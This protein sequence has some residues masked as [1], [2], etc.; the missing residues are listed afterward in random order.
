M[1]DA[2]R[3]RRFSPEILPAQCCLGE[4]S[5]HTLGPYAVLKATYN[6][7]I[8]MNRRVQIVISSGRSAGPRG[9]PPHLSFWQRFKLLITGLTIAVIAVVILVLAL[10]LGSILAAVLWIVLVAVVVFLVLR[11]TLRRTRSRLS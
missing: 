11:A 6:R 4:S 10:V 8:A 5:R 2:F 7:L 1:P 3:Q 9:L